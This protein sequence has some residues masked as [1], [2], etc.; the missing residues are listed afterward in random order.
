[1]H[2]FLYFVLLLLLSLCNASKWEASITFENTEDTLLKRGIFR[3]FILTLTSDTLHRAKAL[4]RVKEDN[5]PFDIIM[6]YPVKIDTHKELVYS[7][8]V[9]ISAQANFT[10]DDNLTIQFEIVNGDS[11]D[12]EIEEFGDANQ[13]TQPNEITV[14]LSTERESRSS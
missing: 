9:G 8:Y 11:D 4:L 1:M 12:E 6:A 13:F 7:F 2:L 14:Q 3:N 5:Y 10:E